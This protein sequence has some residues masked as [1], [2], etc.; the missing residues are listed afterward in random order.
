[1]IDPTKRVNIIIKAKI[2]QNKC[3][4]VLHKHLQQQQLVQYFME[5]KQ[6]KSNKIAKAT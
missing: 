6:I 4:N 2:F 3:V 1:M 5:H